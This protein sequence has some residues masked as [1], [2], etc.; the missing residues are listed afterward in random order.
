MWKSEAARQASDSRT[1]LLFSLR[2]H[3]YV[4][5]C[6]IFP[7]GVWGTSSGAFSFL[8]EARECVLGCHTA[9]FLLLP[10]ALTRLP[11]P[12][13]LQ[14]GGIPQQLYSSE[15]WGVARPK[16]L[17]PLDTWLRLLAGM[18]E[19]CLMGWPRLGA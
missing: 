12:S 9:Q 7:N 10:H 6:L 14:S 17:V 2:T 13:W 8:Q 16:L 18:W 4:L 3:C 19:P 5:C 1:C 15:V 11:S